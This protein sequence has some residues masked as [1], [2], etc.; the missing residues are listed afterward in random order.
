MKYLIRNSKAWSATRL[1][2]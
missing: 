1:S 2:L